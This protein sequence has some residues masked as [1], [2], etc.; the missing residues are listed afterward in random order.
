M[1]VPHVSTNFPDSLDPRFSRIFFEEYNQVPSMIPELFA[2]EPS[3]GRNTV[4]YSQIGTLPDLSEFNGNVVYSGMNQGYDTTLTPVEFTGGIQAERKLMDDVQH[5]IL[6]QRPRA[7]ATA[8][9]RTKEKHGAGFWNNS[10]SNDA[11]GTFYANTEGVAPFSNSH[12]TTSGASTASG[13]DN[14]TTSSLTAAGVSTARIL[15]EGLR[16]DQAE[17]IDLTADELLFPNDLFEEAFEIL[18]SLGKVETANNN[19]NVHNGVYRGIQWRLL[20]SAVDWWLLDSRMRKFMLHWTDRIPIE[21][22][23]VED[24]DTLVKKW[25]AYTRYGLAHTDWR[26]GVGANVS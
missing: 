16:G 8:A 23:M 2:T 3:N 10:F 15:L 9:F 7:L 24:F 1:A 26:F 20:N 19:R 5:G 4:T 12:T 21:F 11:G 14:L 22:A 18:N 17:K 13:F 6:D 25:R